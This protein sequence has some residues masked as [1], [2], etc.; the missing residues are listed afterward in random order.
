MPIY[1]YKCEN[2]HV[3][4]IMQKMSEDRLETCIECE[5][6]V[7]KLMHPVN[8]S[9]KGSG[10]YSTDYKGSKKTEKTEKTDA[11]KSNSTDTGGGSEKSSGSESK[12]ES[13]GSKSS[14]SSSTEKKAVKKD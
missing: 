14:D 6:P 12:S 11:A 5:A 3:F 8:I 1:E 7:K 10:F 2:G 4:D 13:N 9:F